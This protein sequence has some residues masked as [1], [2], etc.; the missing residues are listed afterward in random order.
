MEA[1][2]LVMWDRPPNHRCPVLRIAGLGRARQPNHGRVR[3]LHRTMQPA[4]IFGAPMEAIPT[5][6]ILDV[7]FCGL[8]V[9]H[10]LAFC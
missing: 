2:Q 4:G 7:V 8:H 6:I 3:L 5:G 10:L 9:Y 1:V